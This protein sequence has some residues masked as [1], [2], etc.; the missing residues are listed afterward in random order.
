M[1][2][3]VVIPVYKKKQMFLA[4]LKKNIKY[5]KDV[6]IIV[7]DDGSGENIAEDLKKDFPRIKTLSYEKNRGFAAAVNSGVEVVD[8]DFVLMVN[9]DV[10]LTDD[11]YKKALR[12]F[13]DHAVFAVSF[14]QKE[15]DGRIVGKNKI[16][17]DAGLVAHEGVSD[18]KSGLN[19]WAEGGACIIRRSYFKDLGGFD[20]IYSP[21]YWEDVDLGYRA[22]KRGYKIIF[23]PKILVEHHHE[24]TIGS[25]FSKDFI[26]MIAF[27]NQLIFFWKNIDDWQMWLHH[28]AFLV[29]SV[30]GALARFDF[31]FL[32]AFFGAKMKFLKIIESRAKKHGFVKKDREIMSMFS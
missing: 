29:K 24:T 20:E 15:K 5:L 6:K 16:Y 26:R 11:F 8:S 22:Y 10:V 32:K 23:D 2:L 21:F 4:N 9:S 19:A 3:S 14:A 12:H 31:V 1:T 17:F 18:N 13:D 30:F 28:F 27:R 7:V 25:L